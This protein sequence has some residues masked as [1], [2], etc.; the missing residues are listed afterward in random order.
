MNK[1]YMALVVAVAFVAAPLALAHNPAG[2]PDRFCTGPGKVHDYG[3][4]SGNLIFNYQDG[5][6][7]ECGYTPIF[8]GTIEDL[9]GNEVADLCDP[10]RPI[11]DADRTADW[12]HEL[13]Y[14]NGGAVF[15]ARDPASTDCWDIPAHHLEF[16]TI[17]VQ[18][19]VFGGWMDFF[20]TTDYA[21]TGQDALFPCGDNVSDWCDPTDPAEVPDVTCNP[22]DQEQYCPAPAWPGAW[23]LTEDDP[24]QP[25]NPLLPPPPF[26]TYP[27][28][29]IPFPAGQDGAYNVFIGVGHTAG[30][31]WS[32]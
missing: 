11:C 5:N 18:D 29:S 10:I 16:P 6:L 14:A 26:P 23:P 7:Q 21:P 9:E 13:E 30:H 17:W 20:V 22:R 15:A 27:G 2:T 4:S 28:C 12:D 24:P 1:L 19:N 32:T 8:D 31:V 3:T 25:A